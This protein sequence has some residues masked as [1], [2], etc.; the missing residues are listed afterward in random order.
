MTIKGLFQKK[1]P[2]RKNSKMIPRNEVPPL[3]ND[4][5][6][7]LDLDLRVL[8]TLLLGAQL[9]VEGINTNTGTVLTLYLT[10]SHYQFLL[11]N[12]YISYVSSL[13]KTGGG[14]VCMVIYIYISHISHTDV[15]HV[16][17]I[18]NMSVTANIYQYLSYIPN[19]K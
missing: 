19:D 17:V 5:D 11:I 18:T 10:A 6:L 4:L 14:H 7:I 8:L 1:H 12:I 3:G 2:K 16:P 9:P 15:Y 13:G